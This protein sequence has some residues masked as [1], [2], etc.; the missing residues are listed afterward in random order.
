[1]GPNSPTLAGPA[2][3]LES[4]GLGP[5]GWTSPQTATPTVL[6]WVLALL[7]LGSC[8]VQGPSG[9]LVWDPLRQGLGLFHFL[10]LPLQ[11][12]LLPTPQRSGPPPRL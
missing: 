11:M 3:R 7:L 10:V 1:M 5:H 9:G 4:P 6:H 2:Q 8:C 12:P